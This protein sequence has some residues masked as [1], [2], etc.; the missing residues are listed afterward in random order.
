MG[1]FAFWVS[2]IPRSGYS[3]DIGQVVVAACVLEAFA[4]GHAHADATPNEAE[5]RAL[6]P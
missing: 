2:Y 6:D 1:R 5:L 4:I 3:L